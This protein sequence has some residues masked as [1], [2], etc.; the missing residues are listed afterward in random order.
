MEDNNF[1]RRNFD[2]DYKNGSRYDEN[3]DSY[4]ETYEEYRRNKDINSYIGRSIDDMLR[5]FNLGGLNDRIQKTVDMAIDEV[6]RSAVYKMAKKAGGDIIS[7]IYE[8][9]IKRQRSINRNKMIDRLVNKP[10]GLY[11][12][13]GFMVPS[14]ILSMI[15]SI[16]GVRSEEHTSELQSR[17]YLVCR[18][19]LEK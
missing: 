15:S 5:G 19:L 16:T 7:P 1:N 8:K 12:S 2:H 18:L 9:E 13:I 14:F 3:T 10:R 6:N 11:T 4:Y 17:Q